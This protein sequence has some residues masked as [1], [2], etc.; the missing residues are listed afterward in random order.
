M[1]KIKTNYLLFTRKMS[2]TSF[3]LL[4]CKVNEDVVHILRDCKHVITFWSFFC[5]FTE[6]HLATFYVTST[7]YEWIYENCTYKGALT[8][9]TPWNVFF[10]FAIW[11][12]WLYRNSRTFSLKT[13]LKTHLSHQFVLFFT[14]EYVFLGPFVNPTL[15]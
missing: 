14:I 13:A 6:I 5:H 7:V 1:N 4:E 2:S 3:F 10:T 9:S 8:P 15:P 12:L 11:H